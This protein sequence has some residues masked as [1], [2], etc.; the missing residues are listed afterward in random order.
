VVASAAADS[1]REKAIPDEELRRK[2]TPDYPLGCKRIIPSAKWYPTLN[3]EHV[4]VV[5]SKVTRVQGSTFY[6]EDGSQEEIDV[7]S[8]I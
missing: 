3:L 6:M 2:V 7:S 1:Y 4:E 8:V 5:T